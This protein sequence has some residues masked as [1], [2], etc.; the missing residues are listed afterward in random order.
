MKIFIKLCYPLIIKRKMLRQFSNL[1]Q[2]NAMDM[3]GNNMGFN[4]MD[5]QIETCARPLSCWLRVKFSKPLHEK[6]WQEKKLI[7]K[8]ANYTCKQFHNYKKKNCNLIPVIG[9][10]MI[11]HQLRE[12]GTQRTKDFDQEC[13]YRY[14]CSIN[15]THSTHNQCVK[16]K[17][18]PLDL[19]FD[20]FKCH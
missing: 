7:R 3:L 19:F 14:D 13:C 1:C 15:L 16:S 17:Y 10:C 18:D 12:K 9:H 5:C 2:P 4:M 11:A 6:T 8:L 20:T